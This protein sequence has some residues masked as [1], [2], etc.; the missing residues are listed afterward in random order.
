MQVQAHLN[1]SAAAVFPQLI[2][3][4]LIK[5]INTHRFREDSLRK[6]PCTSLGIKELTL[7]AQAVGTHG[8]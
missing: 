4:M 6:Q 3:L 8:S 7:S 1:K 5:S 2:D